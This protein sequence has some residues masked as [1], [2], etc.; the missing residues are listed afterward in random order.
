MEKDT[1]HTSEED[2]LYMRG[3]LHLQRREYA[4][5]VE[6]LKEY[7]DINSAIAYLSMGK[8]F[9]ASEILSSLKE[10]ASVLYLKAIVASIRGD[11]ES[12][13]NLFLRS[14]ELNLSMAYR[15][16][17][18][19]EISFLIKKYNLNNEIFR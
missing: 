19:P 8:D 9:S 2:T 6:I 15:G 7:R 10:S 3:V 11:E 12:A 5:A 17:L 14:V 18:D 16:A 4:R 13:V 1:I